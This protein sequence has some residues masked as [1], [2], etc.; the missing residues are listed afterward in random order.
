MLHDIHRDP[1]LAIKYGP[2]PFWARPNPLVLRRLVKHQMHLVFRVKIKQMTQGIVRD[3][4]HGK[5]LHDILAGRATFKLHP[6]MH[7]TFQLQVLNFANQRFRFL[8]QVVQITMLKL[9]RIN[10][11]DTFLVTFLFVKD[12]RQMKLQILVV[13][14]FLKQCTHILF[15]TI[16]LRHFKAFIRFLDQRFMAVKSLFRRRLLHIPADTRQ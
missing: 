1:Q 16:P 3:F 2:H 11:G 13:G 8:L 6:E 9:S 5:R 14:S 7:R 15:G 12:S 10:I 4:Q